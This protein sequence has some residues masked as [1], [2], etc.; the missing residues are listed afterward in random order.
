MFYVFEIATVMLVALTMA[1]SVAHALE[2]PGKMRLNKAQY[3]TVQPIYYP[4]FTIGGGAEMLGVFATLALALM[5]PR[6]SPAFVPALIA[7]IA[8]LV[9]HLTYWIATHPVNNFWLR[10]TK[11][12]AAGGSFFA[13][14]FLT[15]GGNTNADWTALRDRWEYSHVARAIFSALALVAVV[16]AVSI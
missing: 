10:D 14:D 5:T 1:L 6:A 15:R 9:T 11:L 16:I 12:S 8:M 2:M 13:F 4:G 7:F 3:L